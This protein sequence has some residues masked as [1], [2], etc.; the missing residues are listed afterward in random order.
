[1]VIVFRC[2]KSNSCRHRPTHRR[3]VIRIDKGGGVS[4]SN[5]SHNFTLCFPSTAS[6]QKMLHRLWS[7]STITH[8]R[9]CGADLA[10][11]AVTAIV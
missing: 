6:E 5:L 1:M 11:V 3:L 8:V 4:V 9:L 7:T 2:K 10:Q